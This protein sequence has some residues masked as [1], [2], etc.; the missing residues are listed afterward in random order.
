M[1]IRKQ[2]YDLA[3]V[4]RPTNWNILNY[5]RV[6]FHQT[7]ILTAWCIFWQSFLVIITASPTLTGFANKFRVDISTSRQIYFHK[8]SFVFF[9]I[10]YNYYRKISGRSNCSKIA[11]RFFSDGSLYIMSNGIA[12]YFCANVV[13]L[14]L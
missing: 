2:I 4:K 12:N 10:L 1:L 14:L 6:F 3:L 8:I 9:Y 13:V 5:I 11:V 7:F